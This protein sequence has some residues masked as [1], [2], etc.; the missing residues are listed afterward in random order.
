MKLIKK[1]KKYFSTHFSASFTLVLGAAVLLM[2]FLFQEYLKSEYLQYLLEKSYETEYAA[3]KSV[4]RNMNESIRELIAKGSEMAIDGELYDL[5]VGMEDGEEDT[6]EIN[7]ARLT[8]RFRLQSYDYVNNAITAAV[9]GPDGLIAQ[10][11]RYRSSNNILWEDEKLQ[12]LEK[13]VDDFSFS[14]KEKVFSRIRA[15]V[16]PGIHPWYT[17]NRIFHVVYPLTGGK[18]SIWTTKYILV[19]SYSMDV[20]EEFLNTIDVPRV[21]YIQGYI[22]D[23]N[24]KI[25]YHN[26][27]EYIGMQ[28][29]DAAIDRRTRL[30]SGELGYF[31][32]TMNI[33]IDEGKM[34]E[35]IDEIYHRG[36][37]GYIMLLVLCV[38]LVFVVFRRLM[39]PVR[40]LSESMRDVEKGNYHA[41]IRVEGQHEIWQVAEEYNRMIE[42]IENKNREIEQQHRE[43]L[44]SVEQKHAAEREALESQINAH[45]ICNTLGCINYEAI[46][47]GNY[48]VSVLIKKLSNILRYTFDQ[49][50]QEVYI[51]QEIAWIDQYLFLQ[52]SRLGDSVRL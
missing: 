40:I 20:F 35:H 25:I 49:K 13:M 11:D 22:A 21:E 37:I 31:G 30:I 8:V 18:E 23:E 14:A 7:N 2:M 48:E 36:V 43:K 33:V 5:I 45:F 9:A 16:E 47:A 12:I 1:I 27:K 42:A 38:S 29:S 26:D 44:L 39:H 50:H 28:E 15:Y 46:E 17:G 10:Y 52:K 34:Q 51:Y 19:I 3:M 4:E 24:G 41:K 32:W 6:K